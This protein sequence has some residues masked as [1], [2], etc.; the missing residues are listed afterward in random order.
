MENLAQIKSY[1][2]DI[3]VSKT[4][5]N[6]LP[7]DMTELDVD[8][9]FDLAEACIKAEEFLCVD[10]TGIVDQVRAIINNEDETEMIDHIDNVC[11]IE[12]FEY[13]FTAKDFL[14]QIG[15]SN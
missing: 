8:G 9:L 2:K 14:E 15:Y 3:L 5:D 11:P 12:Q 4:I 10:E 7:M 6:T 1:I 13:T